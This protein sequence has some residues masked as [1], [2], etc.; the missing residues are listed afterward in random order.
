MK[1][2][3][4]NQLTP[5]Q[6]LPAPL[7]SAVPVSYRLPWSRYE[8]SAPWNAVEVQATMF[9]EGRPTQWAIREGGCVLTK[10][11]E[12][13][14]EPMPSSRTDKFLKRSRWNTWEEAV[15][16]A[17]EFHSQNAQAD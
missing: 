1:S 6:G 17:M 2:P 7:C 13:E 3:E 15:A 5:G 10:K 12:W 4:E 8:N 14:M 9:E 11:R 16:F